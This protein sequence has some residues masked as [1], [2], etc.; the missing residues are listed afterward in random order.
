MEPE[1]RVLP[2]GSYEIEAMIEV[3]P[4]E[5][6][7]KIQGFVTLSIQAVAVNSV[8]SKTS[9][10]VNKT[11]DVPITYEVEEQGGGWGPSPW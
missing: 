5:N 1:I 3:N 7:K 8:N 10:P 6:E 4:G 2:D 9:T 11:Y